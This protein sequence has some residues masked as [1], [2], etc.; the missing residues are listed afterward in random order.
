MI[1][2]RRLRV[3]AFAAF[4]VCLP[5]AAAGQSAPRTD[6]GYVSVSGMLQTSSSFSNTVRPIDFAE[7]A[8]VDTA[9]KPGPMPGIAFGGGVQVRGRLGAGVL[10]S[11]ASKDS[12][13]AVSAQ[14]PHPFFFARPRAVSG[15]ANGLGHS[16]TAVHIQATWTMPL[17]NR[18]SL[19]L[20]GGPTWFSVDQDLV[21]DV[22]VT[23]NY[24]Y[25]TATF[26]SATS[27]HR[28]GSQVGFNAG[29]DV[30]YWLQ[31]RLGLGVGMMFSHASIKLDDTAT[32]DAGGA[33]LSGGIR[34][35]F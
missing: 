22:A 5:L 32:I 25:D 31:P 16:E 21:S 35:R 1:R 10:V 7:A 20:A 4:V 29:A 2:D 30:S 28:S 13:G 17:R 27:A 6:R 15:D 26:A 23:Q 33:Q 18:W 8:V 19:A 24:P 34:F 14:V 3:L 9:Y 11:W 12:T